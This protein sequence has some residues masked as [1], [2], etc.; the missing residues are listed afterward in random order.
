MKNKTIILLLNAKSR[1]NNG[2]VKKWL[3]KSGFM[4]SEVPNIFQAFEVISDFTMR[5]CPEI[6]LLEAVS[7]LDDFYT[8]Q[9]MMRFSDADGIS[10]F[11]LSESEKT[12]NQ[13][14]CFE[15]SF[16][17][18]TAELSL[19]YAKSAKSKTAV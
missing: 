5:Y 1:K 15:G 11:A 18:L 8:I 7:Q 9:K 14:E 4:T 19:L 3:K 17:E 13:K 10:I 2:S 6:V 16:A 12:I